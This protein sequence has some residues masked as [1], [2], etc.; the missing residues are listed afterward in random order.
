M[1]VSCFRMPFVFPGTTVWI[2]T[3][4]T[5]YPQQRQSHIQSTIPETHPVIAARSPSENFDGA[6]RLHDVK[7]GIMRTSDDTL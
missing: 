1:V 3:A 2:G 7:G 4:S 6:Q 5:T